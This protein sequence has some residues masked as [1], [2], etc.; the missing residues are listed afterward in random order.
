[1][2]HWPLTVVIITIYR[3]RFN[4]VPWPGWTT[5]HASFQVIRTF[6]I[7][8]QPPEFRKSVMIHYW[9]Y[10]VNSFALFVT[11]AFGDTV[12]DDIRKVWDFFIRRFS[13]RPADMSTTPSQWIH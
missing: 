7:A 9:T 11:L 3:N 10:T 12:R 1:V 4:L 5:V 13:R 8:A 2:G 6:P